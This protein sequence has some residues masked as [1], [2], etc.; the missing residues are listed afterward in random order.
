M[1]ILLAITA[2]LVTSCPLW[3]QTT[4]TIKVR[5]MTRDFMETNL[6]H[7]NV[8]Y[9]GMGNPVTILDKSYPMKRL[10]LNIDNGEI[11][12]SGGLIVIKADKPGNA[13]VD[14]FEI[15]PGN[16]GED[17][18]YSYIASQQYEVVKIPVPKA[19]VAG[20]KHGGIINKDYLLDN[21]SISLEVEECEHYLQYEIE[22]FDVVTRAKGRVTGSRSDNNTLS[23]D[24]KYLI[25]KVKKD[26]S[27]AF[28]NIT[29]RMPDGRSV[30]LDPVVLYIN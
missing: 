24:Q 22:G 16:N 7:C 30:V 19:V 29:V 18:G 6:T 23:K 15:I 9:A 26:G 14:I 27:V 4:G 3:S 1:K 10:K 11:D 2:L 5:K 13:V 8:L 28:D 20:K 12:N 21:G 25:K 17:P